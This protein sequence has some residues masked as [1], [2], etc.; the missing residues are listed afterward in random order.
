MG[1]GETEV[2]ILITNTTVYNSRSSRVRVNSRSKEAIVNFEAEPF[3]ITI[4]I[5]IFPQAEW[6]KKA[7]SVATNELDPFF[8]STKS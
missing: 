6:R 5:Y 2:G 7:G 1:R 8:I 3:I 4:P